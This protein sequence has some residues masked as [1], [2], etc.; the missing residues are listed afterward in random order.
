MLITNCLLVISVFLVRDVDAYTLASINF[1]IYVIVLFGV[2][3]ESLSKWLTIQLSRRN[4][5]EYKRYL[6]SVYIKASPVIVLVLSL[7]SAI[8]I[9]FYPKYLILLI[10]CFTV[11]LLM[12]VYQ[13]L[14]AWINSLQNYLMLG[15]LL[16]LY[17]LARLISS[18]FVSNGADYLTIFWSFIAAGILLILSSIVFIYKREK[19]LFIVPKSY[20]K[21]TDNKQ[22]ILNILIQLAINTFWI[23]DGIVLNKIL[24]VNIYNTYVT[25]SFIYKFPFFLSSSFLLVVLGQNI[26]KMKSFKAFLKTVLRGILLATFMYLPVIIFEY[27]NNGWILKTMGYGRFYIPSLSVLFGI[28]WFFQTIVFML[29]SSIVKIAKFNKVVNIQIAVYS[30]SFIL[31]LLCFSNSIPNLMTFIL[32]HGL[33]FAILSSILLYR[34]IFQPKR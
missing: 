28:S 22:I 9:F 8:F 20:I 6:F 18:Y 32:F 23:L 31:G 26:S 29:Y 4:P 3:T 24:S 21:N 13:Y 25:Y 11:S 10:T 33:A 2:L 5:K 7:I 15:F 14:R 16:T 17:P 34:L 1:G 19:T 30:L 12:Y 27:F